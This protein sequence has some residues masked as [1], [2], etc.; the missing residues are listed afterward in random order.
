MNA[1]GLAGDRVAALAGIDVAARGYRLHFCKGDYFALAPRAPIE[2]S[3]LVYPLP[4]GPGLGIHATLDL[5]GRV[6]FGP[7]AEFVRDLDYAVDAEKAATFATSAAR[8]LPALRAEWLSPDYAGIR[9]RLAGVGEPARDF[10]VQEES[11]IG[12]PGFVNL[13]GIESPGLTAALAIG[14]EVVALLSGL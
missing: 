5:G 13:I 2:L 7:D 6:R 14:E 10:V 12:L 3:K 11:A 9:P 4:A 1:A 8:Y